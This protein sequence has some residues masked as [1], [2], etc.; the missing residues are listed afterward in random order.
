M[1]DYIKPAL[2]L[3]FNGACFIGGLLIMGLTLGT[4]LG[5]GFTLGARLAGH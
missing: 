5:Y 4:T 1:L 3:G 2:I